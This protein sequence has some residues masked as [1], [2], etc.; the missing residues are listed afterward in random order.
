VKTW[1]AL[2]RGINVGGS[3]ILPMTDLT[4]LLERMGCTD[5]KA[6]IQSGNV[7]FRS[8]IAEASRVASRIGNAVADHHG[9][10]PHVLI[11]NPNELQGAVASN[12]FR[13]A[14]TVPK[15]LHLY[16]LSGA[17]KSPD[18]KSMHGAKSKNEAFALKGRILYLHTPDGFGKSKLAGRVERWLGVEAT[19]RNW[20]TVSTLLKLAKAYD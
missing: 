9:F 5:V 18:L 13:A 1:I 14:E 12:P 7:I 8:P 2:F 20:R 15:S 4:A 16:F 19:A 11:L 3:H 6:Y 17:P 10:Q